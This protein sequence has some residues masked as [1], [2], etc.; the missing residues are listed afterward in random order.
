MRLK[1]KYLVLLTQLNEVK[2][3]ITITSLP[4]STAVTAVENKTPNASN[5][6]NKTDR[7]TKTSETENKITTNHDH[8]Y[9]ILLLKNLIS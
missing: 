1:E 2:N 8:K 9:I 5:I 4:T 3:K 7:N 6:V